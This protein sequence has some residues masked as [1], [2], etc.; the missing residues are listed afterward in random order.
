VLVAAVRPRLDGALITAVILMV[1]WVLSVGM[2]LWN[3]M[4][5]DIVAE[6]PVAALATGA[7]YMKMSGKPPEDG[8]VS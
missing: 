7:L 1:G 8:G 4:E 5:V 6:L 3:R 2:R